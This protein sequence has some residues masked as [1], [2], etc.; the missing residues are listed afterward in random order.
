VKQ[1]FLLV[2]LVF[3]NSILLG[4]LAIDT[5][6]PP[7]KPKAG[8][9]SNFI[10]QID[11][12]TESYY[13]VRGRMNGIK[14][15]VEFYKRFRTGFGFYQN[16]DFYRIE[17]P[18]RVDTAFRSASFNYSTY[19][20]E[21]VFLR[22]FRWEF[23]SI[24]QFGSGSIVVKNYDYL[25]GVP[26]FS[27]QDTVNNVGVFDIGLNG[28]FKVFPW[29]GLGS[30][31]GV[32]YVNSIQDLELKGAF[33]DTYVDFKLKIFLGYIYKGIFKPQAIQAERDYYE[34]REAKRWA[35]VKKLFGK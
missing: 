24:A 11:N 12:R 4:Q 6:P 10:F 16:N 5:T 34:W 13:D 29:L 26:N 25:G 27:R 35:S 8:F 14:L 15:G 28:H 23:S 17:P 22:N 33:R 18:F 21:I 3:L 32:R 2:A 20:A 31:V 7:P 1:W 19:F 9:L 30:G